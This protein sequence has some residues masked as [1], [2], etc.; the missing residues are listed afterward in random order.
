MNPKKTIIPLAALFVVIA[1]AFSTP[2]TRAAKIAGVEEP[3]ATGEAVSPKPKVPEKTAPLPPPSRIVSDPSPSMPAV[4]KNKD[5]RKEIPVEPKKVATAP[6]ERFVTIDFDNVDIRVFIKFI[7]EIAGRNFVVDKDVRGAVTIVSPRKISVDEA[8]RVFESVLEVHGYTAV[9]AGEIVK[10]IPVRDARQKNVETRLKE[11]A[12]GA[13]DRV[14]TQIIGLQYANPDDIKT[15]LTPLV[16]KES[17]VLS[18]PPT[19]MLVVTDLL[20]NIQRLLTIVQALDAEGLEEQIAVISLKYASSAEIAKSLNLIF[21]RRV[22]LAKR[23]EQTIL[24]IVSDD[25][26]NS[27]IALASENETAKIRELVAL[28]DREI[29]RGEERVRVYH[30]KNA[31]SEELAKVL[32]ALPVKDGKTEQKPQESLISKDV[33]IIPDKATNTLVITA[34]RDDY[35]VLEKV[36]Q[37]LDVSRPMVYI[38]A[39][40]MEVSFNRGF[41]LGAE[42]VYGDDFTSSGR[43]SAYGAGFIGPGLARTDN[44]P[45]LPTGFSVGVFGEAITIGSVVFPSLSAIFQAYESDNEVD[46][47]STPQIL[48]LD[49]QEAEIYVGENVPYLS[50]EASGDQ[51]YQIYEYRDVGVR[52]KITPQISHE[53]FVR[54]NIYQ[55]VTKVVTES[56]SSYRPRTLK[57]T[58]K[59]AVTIK[60]N[61][62]LVIGGLIGDDVS[63]STFKVPC[64]G[65]IPF[66]GWLFKYESQSREKRN[67]FIFITPHIMENPAEA[68]SL[69]EQKRDAIEG[70][71][72]GVIRMRDRRPAPGD[73]LKLPEPPQ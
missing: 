8:Y 60:D 7:S 9:P 54:L 46:I 69:Y 44:V 66:L 2:S 43:K 47:L 61:N 30:L 10:V 58:A 62:T 17:V 40:I 63:N 67:L 38:E 56:E 35:A 25:R 50:K 18:Y 36:I 4:P 6:S 42:W 19:G 23:T 28:L 73:E 51:N 26:T 16:S 52:L 70:A 57:R 34:N 65:N 55:E 41:N 68:T 33:Q 24:K 48:T 12:S 49:N 1:I 15:V 27:I 72:E 20:S 21:Q 11:Q 45:P 71:K 37:K 53:R 39:L 31:D 22:T 29:P 3:V 5:E 13:E 64:L 14:V 32:M 59:T